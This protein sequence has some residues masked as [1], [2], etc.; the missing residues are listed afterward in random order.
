MMQATMMRDTWPPKLR[1]ESNMCSPLRT[2]I[3]SY[4]QHSMA[5]GVRHV[6]VVSWQ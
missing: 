5:C 1:V 3:T 4:A 2:M 6:G